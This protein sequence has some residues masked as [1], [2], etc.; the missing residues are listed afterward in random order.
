VAIGPLVERLVR[1]WRKPGEVHDDRSSLL[2][3]GPALLVLLLAAGVV[4]AGQAGVPRPTDSHAQADA[5]TWLRKRVRPGEGVVATFNVRSYLAVELFG[6]EVVRQLP[7]IRFPQGADPGDYVWLGLR[8]RA[9]LG[10]GEEEWRTSLG[11]A[12]VRYLVVLY[13]SPT[14]PDEL[15]SLLSSSRSPAGIELAQRFGGVG[16][17]AVVFRV[18]PTGIVT[19][20]PP[21]LHLRAAAALALLEGSADATAQAERLAAEGAVVVGVASERAPLVAALPDGYCLTPLGAPYREGLA[22]SVIPVGEGAC[23]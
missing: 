9:L 1:D 5:A 6:Q 10:L 21:P 13:P 8:D 3:L 4:V 7:L 16:R 20:Q 12:D 15:V 2:R 22:T 18:D 17:R 14:S 23:V 11:A 19:G